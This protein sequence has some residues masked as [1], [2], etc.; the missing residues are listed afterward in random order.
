MTNDPVDAVIEAYIDFLDGGGEE[1]VLDHLTSAERALAEELIASL[2]AGRGMDPFRPRPPLGALLAGTEF[3]GWLSAP[4]SS[5]LLSIE[6]IRTDVIRVLGSGITLAADGAAT[7][8]EL[9]SHG[10]LTVGTTRL[11]VQLRA[12]F[13]EPTELA[14]LDPAVAAGAIFGR[15][16]DTVG[17]IVVM[18]DAARSS[19]AI[20]PFD[21]DECIGA[22]DGILRAPRVRRPVL[23][24]CDVLRA[25]LSEV[26]PDLTATSPTIA[27]EQL[28]LTDYAR[29]AATS[30]IGDIAV[31]GSKARTPAKTGTWSA[32]NGAEIDALTALTVAVA[33]GELS[34]DDLESELERLVSTA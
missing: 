5:D 29:A 11:R 13:G 9:L 23:P 25:Y 28:D 33:S 30:A 22:P 8:E 18:G 10:V 31:E 15:F 26:A 6:S 17:V 1:P 4:V 20:G 12:D 7:V 16:P 34:P 21:V 32:M 24:L 19:V 14:E 27:P 3:E 2:G